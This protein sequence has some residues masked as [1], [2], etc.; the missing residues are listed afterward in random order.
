MRS[1][2]PVIPDRLDGQTL[3]SNPQSKRVC[4]PSNRT[5]LLSRLRANGSA[6]SVCVCKYRLD[7]SDRLDQASIDTGFRRS[8]LRCSVTMV[9][10]W[11]ANATCGRAGRPV[12]GSSET[13]RL[14]GRNGRVNPLGS[15]VLIWFID[16]AMW[17]DRFE[18]MA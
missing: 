2:R 1:S 4:G 16:G 14:C 11:A 10:R 12:R 9:G 7:G 13:K 15:G 18:V 6:A 17:A 3:Q 8:N 5:N